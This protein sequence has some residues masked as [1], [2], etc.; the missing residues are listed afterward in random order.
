MAISA[1]LS[2]TRCG[3]D[4]PE[5]A[6]FCLACGY[7]L[8]SVPEHA[9][10][11]SNTGLLVPDHVLNQRYRIVGQVGKGGFGA[12][13]KAEDILFA[14][15]FVA[16]KEM[17]QS[18]L[19]PDE[20]VIATEAFKR[21]AQLLASLS[22]PGLPHIYDQ[23]FEGSHWYLAMDF[24]EGKTLDAY[25]RQAPMKRILVDEALEIGVKLC[26]V[27]DYLHTREPPIVFRDLKPAN[28]MLTPDGRVV[29]IDFGIARHFKPGQIRDTVAFGSPGYAPPEQ[30]G[31]GQTTPR[32]DIFSLGATLHQV[33]SGYDPAESPFRFRPLHLP[34]YQSL[35]GLD[36]FIMHMVELDE[37]N[38]PISV[39]AVKQTLQSFAAQ[40][41]TR[42]ADAV[43]P[44]V[45]YPQPGPLPS[46]KSWFRS[47]RSRQRG[48]FAPS[49][50]SAAYTTSADCMF[51]GHTGRVL[52]AA[53]SWDSKLIASCGGD[54]TVQVWDTRTGSALFIYLGHEQWVKTVAW[55]PDGTRIASAGADTTVQV[56]DALTGGTPLFYRG[57]TNIV[58]MLAWSPDGKYIASVGYD[59]TL[60]VWDAHS[61]EQFGYI[62][63]HIGIVNALAWSP[64]GSFIATASD[65]GTVQIWA[66][67]KNG[68]AVTK[69]PVFVYRG[70]T[71]KVSTVAWSPNGRRM[72]SGGWD[73]TVQVWDA[74]TGDFVFTHRDHTSW[75]NAV[76]W[77]PN[78]QCVASA[79]N[80]ASVQVWEASTGR[81][82][83][84]KR[85]FFT[86][87]GHNEWVRDVS[88]SPDGTRIASCG[89]D[90]TVQVWQ[91]R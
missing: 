73:N 88:W 40:W 60:Q 69:T 82:F 16:V 14:D 57:H 37:G 39:A 18:W 87:N 65:D 26:T 4:N 17:G 19:T 20:A 47:A 25:L 44:R 55:S 66:I 90:Q 50:A 76:T 1:H 11:H 8:R 51:R 63:E 72:A 78:S 31:K 53:W 54:C 6:A 64:N 48:A 74:L 13:Y 49:V 61:A 34:P 77:S 33:L 68:S 56:W 41:T 24:I 79:S 45:L 81:E 58:S 38:R 75:I 67:A 46:G 84:T 70:H 80:D 27:L 5:R 3:T 71:D 29:L 21:E 7:P 10:P 30:Y 2:C 42:Q 36:I 91:A 85:N 22:H 35:P 86:Y 83:F 15:R 89:H 32:A 28:V 59:K 62:H 43:Q 52:A 12:V 9:N 23:F